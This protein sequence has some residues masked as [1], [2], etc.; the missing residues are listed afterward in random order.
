MASPDQDR[1]CEFVV[2]SIPNDPDTNRYAQNY[3][4]DSRWKGRIK[5]VEG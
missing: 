1:R 4:A 2:R 3:P 5:V